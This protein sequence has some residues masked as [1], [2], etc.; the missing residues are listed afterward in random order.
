MAM[1]TETTKTVGVKRIKMFHVNIIVFCTLLMCCCA[2]QAQNLGYLFVNGS[3]PPYCYDLEPNEVCPSN[4]V[5]Y[6]ILGFNKSTEQVATFEL[7]VVKHALDTL[8]YFHVTEACRES[9]RVY[10]CSNNFAICTPDSKYGVD[11]KYDFFRTKVACESIKSN[12]PA[13]LSDVLTFNCSVI[14]KDASGYTY[15]VELP[16][17]QGDVCSKSRYK[18]IY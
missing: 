14:Q 4:L 5:S 1:A 15:C 8:E 13:M 18:V 10:S 12:C 6:K 2:N 17:V 7:Q 11:L 9:V 16:E 3:Q